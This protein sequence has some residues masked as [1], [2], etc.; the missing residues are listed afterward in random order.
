MFGVVWRVFSKN[1]KPIAENK[2]VKI[3]EID[4]N[5]FIVEEEKENV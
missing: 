4:G 2:K 3:L 1:K 5:K